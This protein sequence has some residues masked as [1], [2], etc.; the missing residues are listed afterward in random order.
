MSEKTATIQ[1]LFAG[2]VFQNEE[3]PPPRQE[4]HAGGHLSDRSNERASYGADVR[5]PPISSF[6]HT[7]LQY[8][9]YSLAPSPT[10]RNE[11][12]HATASLQRPRS[13]QRA[14][15]GGCGGS[16]SCGSTPGAYTIPHQQP[17][18][19]QENQEMSNLGGMFDFAGAEAAPRSRSVERDMEDL[20]GGGAF[21][22]SFL[23]SGGGGRSAYSPNPM[24][25][26]GA[27]G[28]SSNHG[29]G[30][31]GETSSASPGDDDD[32]ASD[33]V[34]P[35]ISKLSHLLSHSDY[36]EFIRWNTSGD[37]FI[38][39]HTS[40][41]LLDIF[42]RFFRH[43][44][45]HSFV[46]QLNIYGFTRLSTLALLS[47]IDSVSYPHSSLSASDFSGFSHPLFWRE[48]PGHPCDLAKIKP[49]SVKSKPNGGHIVQV[50]LLHASNI[51]CIKLEDGGLRELD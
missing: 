20:L 38:F 21:G 27:S 18:P 36:T 34:T 19:K 23:A 37:S 17:V 12:F 33:I 26:D 22:S 45:V 2:P 47:A 3:P 10:D 44:N 31:P 14:L 24:Q 35:F 32:K 25:I 6:A 11:P 51:T 50:F 41:D 13:P 28:P 4:D 5:L 48:R 43:S 16:T 46:R 40:P 1:S 9:D 7:S 29:G 39:A 30:S 42:A 49:K 8:Q 15:S